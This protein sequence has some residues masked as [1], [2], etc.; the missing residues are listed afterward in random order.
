ME[1]FII[2][3]I[4]TVV[5]SIGVSV[6]KLETTTGTAQITEYTN[7]SYGI[8]KYYALIECLEEINL[9]KFVEI[10]TRF[11]FKIKNA[12]NALEGLYQGR[13]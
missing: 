11:E 4:C 10:H 7:I 3:R 12:L 9:D 13:G 1:Q 2:D 6:D 8:G 5:Q